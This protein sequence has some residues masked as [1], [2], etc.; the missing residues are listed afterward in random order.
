MLRWP[1]LVPWAI[2]VTGAGYVG[3]RAGKNVVDGWAAAIGV[4]LLLA[5]ELAIWSIE[6]DARIAEE[7][8]AHHA[9]H[10][11]ARPARRAPRC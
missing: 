7:R 4:L 3:G 8:V 5:A 11:D 1:S 9:A 10:R 2:F 6:H